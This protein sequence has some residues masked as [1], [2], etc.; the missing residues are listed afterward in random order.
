MRLF[1]ADYSLRPSCYD[2]P[3][4]GGRSGSD[5]TIADCWGIHKLKDWKCD[6]R[7]TSIVLPHNSKADEVIGKNP[8]TRFPLKLLRKY[9]RSYF[10]SVSRPQRRDEFFEDFNRGVS[11]DVLASKYAIR[12]RGVK[13]L[14]GSLKRK[15]RLLLTQK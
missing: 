8:H 4:K 13:G 14:I 7:G 3:A 1:L 2:C 11:L 10:R 5:V 9:N 12:D 6:D 15:L